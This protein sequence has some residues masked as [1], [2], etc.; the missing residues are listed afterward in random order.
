MNGSSIMLSRTGP[1]IALAVCAV[2]L[3]ALLV[4]TADAAARHRRHK[5]TR[6]QGYGFLPGV[7]SPERIE[8]ERRV[9]RE[10]D[11]FNRWYGYPGYYRGRWNGGGF[12]PCWTYT[13]IGPHYNCG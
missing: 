10:R 8:W 4:T 11:T 2:A 3:T 9:A 12:G 6:W 5:T 13:P 1:R 7:R